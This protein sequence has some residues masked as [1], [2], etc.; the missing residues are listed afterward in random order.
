[1]AAADDAALVDSLADVWTSI[2][3]FAAT[4]TEEEW[5]TATELPGWTVQ[6]NLAHI[7][8]I[9]SDL[10]GRHAPTAVDRD[11]PHVKN[12]LGLANERWVD[13]YRNRSGATVLGDFREVTAVRLGVLRD[14]AVDFGAAAWT[15]IGPGTVRDMLPFRVFD[16]W[17]HEQ[18]MRRAVGRPGGWDTSAAALALDRMVE[19]M[20]MVVGKKVGPPDET[21]V[22][23]A[24]T[25]P[26]ERDVVIAMAD[27]R[28]AIAAE[29]AQAT[30][31]LRLDAETFVRLAAGRGDPDE[32][33]AL[34]TFEG[35]EALGAAVVRE[36]NFLF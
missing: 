26:V 1:V 4:L 34:V 24:I 12:D 5:K 3:T 27:G 35:D 16:A 11:W 7:I 23:F 30:V 14:P 28:A 8:G 6:D 33:V 25:G 22:A 13:A 15:P 19:I 2:D 31:T 21:V 32:V 17:V 9:E 18:D 29:G 36:M 10:L 20:P